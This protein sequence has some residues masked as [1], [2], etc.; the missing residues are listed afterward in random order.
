MNPEIRFP[1]SAAPLQVSGTADPL[2]SIAVGAG[3]SSVTAPL[4]ANRTLLPSTQ[5]SV[6]YRVD[7]KGVSGIGKVQIYITPIRV[8][9]GC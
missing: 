4:P 9:P 7:Q 6:D 8:K 2:P 3:S 5:A 1:G